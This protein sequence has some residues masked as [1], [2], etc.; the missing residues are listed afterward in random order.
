MR[1]ILKFVND[2]LGVM[3]FAVH[4]LWAFSWPAPVQA[5]E[6]RV[7]SSGRYFQDASGQP[8]F[9]MGYYGWASVDPSFTLQ[10]SGEY[11][12]MMDEGSAHGLN[13]IRVSL[14]VNP[15]PNK[16]PI[17]FETV[18]GRAD[19]EHWDST[20]WSSLR[21]LCQRAQE[22]GMLIHIA[23]FDGVGLRKGTEWWR[24]D[25]SFWN[26]D[27]Q[28]GDFFGDLDQDRDGNADEDGDFYRVNDF[29]NGTGVGK[30][31]RRV[32]DK[33]ISETA[34]FSNVFFEV[35]NELFGAKRAWYETVIAYIR[36]K[37]NKPITHNGGQ[38]VAGSDGW[39]QHRASTP[40][41]VKTFVA[42]I[43]GQGYPAWEDP[44][45][46]F[47]LMN[48]TPDRLRRAAW[49]S[50]AGGAAAWGGFTVDFRTSSPH[51]SKLDYYR[52][53][54]GFIKRTNVKFW[55]MVPNHGLVSNSGQNSCLAKVGEA[56]LVYVAGGATVNLDLRGLSGQVSFQVYDPKAGSFGPVGTKS[57]EGWQTFE[58]PPNADDWV[59]YATIVEDSNDGPP[60]VDDDPA[61]DDEPDVVEPPEDDDPADRPVPTDSDLI[62]HWS[63]DARAGTTAFDE[64][65]RAHHGTFHNGPERTNGLAGG[66]GALRFDGK[67]DYVT[68]SDHPDLSPTQLTI[69][70]WVHADAAQGTILSKGSLSSL[71][72]SIYAA[73]DGY[74]V[75]LR[76]DSQTVW[77]S[78]IAPISVDAPQHIALTWNNRIVRVYIDGREVVKKATALV[79][80]R[81]NDSQ[82]PLFLGKNRWSN[83]H[84]S[85]VI[86]D[87]RIYGIAL[88]ATEIKSI[89]DGEDTGPGPADPGPADPDPGDGPSEDPTGPDPSG[90]DDSV[91]EPV[92]HWTMDG[93]SH[94]TVVDTSGRG[95]NGVIHN[96]ARF[97]ADGVHGSS[98]LRFD[99][100]D[101]YVSVADHPDLSPLQLTISLWVNAKHSRGTILS[102]GSLSSLHFSVQA[103]WDGYR[104]N[105]KSGHQ[106][107]RLSKIAPVKTG[108][109]QHIAVTWDN[110][111]VRVFVDG[112]EI[113]SKA[114][115]LVG[116]RINDSSLPLHIG[117]NRWDSGHFAGIVDDVRIYAQALSPSEIRTLSGK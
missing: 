15:G 61:D 89:V 105:V 59:L 38:K 72:Y 79:G 71:H 63:M 14:G 103:A 31:Q 54:Q 112:S 45:G 91:G 29:N 56:Y 49:Y 68:V 73:W 78:K 33:A 109:L 3:F 18:N 39:A 34:A 37:T 116:E 52:N 83:G 117:R 110:R 27:N 113:S 4:L 106:T 70:L 62:A 115:P 92:A 17:V 36:S 43:V 88:E 30:Y 35:G 77:I 95:H 12:H 46:P 25:N 6:P 1:S 16:Q 19:P 24:W 51:A 41:A 81:I 99:G 55:D 60:P 13:Y 66:A 8:V 28:V 32:I 101:D 76:S 85:G 84:F 94:P 58:R 7:H 5:A 22:K 96:G 42:S 87:V 44:D 23:I 108:T 47:G 93:G 50:F 11:V 107:V 90:E 65:G 104:V 48:G 97:T 10:D 114:S 98:A 102:K 26:R 111:V 74:R 21:F 64:S 80:R 40:A 57:I 53:L 20:F 100:I 9:L 69:A 82:V 75:A 2:L 67:D 86:D